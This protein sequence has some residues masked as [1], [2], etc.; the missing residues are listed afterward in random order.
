M[1]QRENKTLY[2][3]FPDVTL[4]GIRQ[5]F[6]HFVF[7]IVHITQTFSDL[8]LYYFDII[9]K[10]LKSMIKS[11]LMTCLAEITLPSCHARQMRLLR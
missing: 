9:R 10:I 6:S 5:A 4:T 2:Q 8:W 11:Q 7:H 1:A 3:S